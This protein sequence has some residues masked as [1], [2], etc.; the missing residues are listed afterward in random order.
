M[1]IWQLLKKDFKILL[2]SKSSALIVILGPLLVIFLLG[3]AFDTSNQYS[4]NVATYSK[5][6][7]DI[8]ESMLSKL[9]E[10]N[11][12]V[13]KFDSREGCLASIEDGS[14]NTCIIFPKDLS[15]DTE[16]QPEI[17]FY[18]DYSKLNL[19]Y[20][21]LDTLSSKL[22]E[23]RDDLSKTL[24]QTLVSR[25][26]ETRTKIFELQPKVDSII[27]NQNSIV[28]KINS[29][30]SKLNDMNLNFNK[31]DFEISAAPDLSASALLELDSLKSEVSTYVNTVKDAVSDSE[32]IISSASFTNKSTVTSD[33]SD[34]NSDISTIE[35]LVS[36]SHTLIKTDLD[37][38]NVLVGKVGTALTTIE[39]QM[40]AAS[41]SKTILLKTSDEINSLTSDSKNNADI[42]KAQLIDMDTS[43]GGIKVK[44]VD[45]IVSPFKTTIKPITSKKSNLNY[46][47]PSLLIL[48]IM[49]ISIILSNTIIQM[50][51]NSP[52][53]FRNSITPVSQYIYLFG[54][55]LTNL[56]IVFVQLF[57]ILIISSVFFE[58]Q[59]LHS[60]PLILLIT[61]LG[62]TL[63]SLVGIIIGEIFKSEET[64]MLASIAV[65]AI[66]LFLSNTILPLESMPK[67]VQS[68]ANY[69]PFV[70]LEKILR[71]VILYSH[72]FKPIMY[73]LGLI[74]GILLALL[75]YLIMH[76][77][78]VNKHPVHKALYKTR[79]WWKRYKIKRAEKNNTNK[80]KNKSQKT[81]T[82][83]ESKKIKE[84]T[85]TPK[86]PKVKKK[87]NDNS[88]RNSGKR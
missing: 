28:E 22:Y 72:S 35:T 42:I 52:A 74:I 39:T 64:A 33:L 76:I 55:Y 43:I 14:H 4:I 78:I 56:I 25:L 48:V 86:N 13:D 50:E 49:F 34:I 41:G 24:T 79:E 21:L 1:K 45:K 46:L 59:I 69:N 7:N 12:N 44:S 27:N 60:L 6:F 54:S 77:W 70:L 18:V 51:R 84:K 53:Y 19:V 38:L 75:I 23:E 30:K 16:T 63:F 31:D 58:T 5:G 87:S 20:I 11:F 83:K 8:S 32:A 81:E 62:I 26:Q 82:P 3:I 57:V 88:N 37:A 10:N 67:L 68:I 9:V 2:R 15:I 17:E 66:F 73:E 65:S 29:E 40:A 36:D 71:E 85:K 47:F 80:L 61:F